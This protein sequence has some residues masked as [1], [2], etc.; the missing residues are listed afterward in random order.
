MNSAQASTRRRLHAQNLRQVY[1]RIAA[2]MSPEGAKRLNQLAG[3]VA[4]YK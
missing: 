4:T 3:D 2:S 1:H